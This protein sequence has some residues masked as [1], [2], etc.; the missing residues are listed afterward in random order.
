MKI[1]TKLDKVVLR[2]IK[3]GRGR[4]RPRCL[5]LWSCV[6]GVLQVEGLVGYELCFVPQR[7]S[8]LL[9]FGYGARER[10]REK[11]VVTFD[12]QEHLL[13]CFAP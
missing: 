6:L 10:A 9:L 12:L 11:I 1:R 13:E 7:S 8:T 4:K 5:Y 3:D 2:G